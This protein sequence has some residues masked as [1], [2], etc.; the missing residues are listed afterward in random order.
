MR[1]LGPHVFTGRR[2]LNG[3]LEC[4]AY[5]A[6]EFRVSVNAHW[7]HLNIAPLVGRKLFLGWTW[8][9]NSRRP[10][11]SE[12]TPSLRSPKGQVWPHFEP[13]QH[14]FRASVLSEYSTSVKVL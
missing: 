6:F 4:I 5:H 9:C 13:N 7:N 10:L 12:L 14:A 11:T 8:L 3:P 1:P 2:A